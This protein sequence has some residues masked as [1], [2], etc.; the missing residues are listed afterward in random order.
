MGDQSDYGET[1]ADVYDDWYGDISDVHA[2]VAKIASLLPG[3][4]RDA[5]IVE[6]GVGTGRVAFALA[7]EGANVTGIDN[8]ESML[9][10]L[11]V[12]DP[13]RHIATVLGDMSRDIPDGNFDVAVV[14]FNTLFNLLTASDQQRFFDHV[15]SRLRPGGILLIEANRFLVNEKVETSGTTTRSDGTV[16]RSTSRI[17]PLTNIVSGEFDDGKKLRR[18]RIRYANTAEI[19]DMAAKAGLVL[20]ERTESASGGVFTELSERHLSVFRRPILETQ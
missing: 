6:C 7:D 18:W 8:S 13:K 12:N 5:E 3:G 17:D 4:I 11:R 20:L 10:I 1:F 19:D 14:A 16:V 2:L 9:G 15:A